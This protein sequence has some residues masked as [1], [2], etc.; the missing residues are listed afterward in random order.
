M[1]N[2][3][4]YFPEEITRTQPAEAFPPMEELPRK[5]KPP[6][7]TA[8]QQSPA[9]NETP[10]QTQPPP[11]TD[12]MANSTTGREEADTIKFAIAKLNDYLR[13]FL[14]V[15]EVTLL[16]EFFLMLIGA[17]QDNPFAGFMYALTVIPLYPFNN[18]VH[19]TELGNGG[20]V[21]DW[22]I[23]IAMA[24]YFLVFYALRLFLRILI[25]GPE[26]PE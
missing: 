3:S 21:I 19:N 5:P 18:I 11:P 24:V 4:N 8:Q 20:A 16:I 13:W 15:L 14:L 17:A 10:P 22:S 2:P 9:S 12:V 25:S 1:Q 23:L 26:E 7:N 6:Q